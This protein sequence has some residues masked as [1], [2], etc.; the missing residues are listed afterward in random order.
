MTLVLR[1]AK[2]AH[3]FFVPVDPAICVAAPEQNLR[4][5]GEWE[6]RVAVGEEDIQDIG[7]IDFALAAETQKPISRAHA[8]AGHA[9][10]FAQ[11]DAAAEIPH[12]DFVLAAHE[13]LSLTLSYNGKRCFKPT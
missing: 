11:A 9:R 1:I 4:F 5:V 13:T 7:N 2:K 10:D 12:F 3:R 6:Q 8:A